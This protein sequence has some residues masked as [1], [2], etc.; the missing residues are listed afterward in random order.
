MPE[1]IFVF[2][3]VTS[4][5]IYIVSPEILFFALISWKSVTLTESHPSLLTRRGLKS[6]KKRFISSLLVGSRAGEQIR[7]N[8]EI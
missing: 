6:G 2:G 3:H 4:Y 1:I 8:D 7:G 5:H